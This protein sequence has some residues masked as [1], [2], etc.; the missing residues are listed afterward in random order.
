MRENIYTI[1]IIDVSKIGDKYIEK[2]LIFFNQQQDKPKK[3]HKV[4]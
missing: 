4:D 2:F 3:K 1:K